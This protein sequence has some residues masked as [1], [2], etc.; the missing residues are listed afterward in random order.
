MVS[1]ADSLRK[2][3]RRGEGMTRRVESDVSG[4]ARQRHDPV[5]TY[6]APAVARQVKNTFCT[7]HGI[8]SQQDSI[9]NGKNPHVHL[10]TGLA[11][12]RT[13]PQLFAFLPDVLRCQGAKVDIGESRE[14]TEQKGVAHQQ[15]RRV[16]EVEPDK[17][18]Y[19]GVEMIVSHHEL[20]VR[21]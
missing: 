5:E 10:R 8:V 21:L 2:C 4:D 16:V 13:Y 6:V 14:T 18:P 11:A 20:A 3:D 19:F 17:P 1:V 9:R 15:Q 7:D 12:G